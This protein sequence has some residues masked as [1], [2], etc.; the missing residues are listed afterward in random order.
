MRSSSGACARKL[1]VEV[2][3][4]VR[5]LGY[6][7]APPDGAPARLMAGTGMTGMASPRSIETRLLVTGL[8]LSGLFLLITGFVLSSYYRNA[9]E[10][11][12]DESLKVSAVALIADVVTFVEEPGRPPAI[13]AIRASTFS[14]PAGTG[15]SR[16]RPAS[17][18]GRIKRETVF[19]SPSLAADAIPFLDETAARAGSP[20]ERNALIGGHDG[21]QLRLTEQR[22]DLGP[23][24]VFIVSVAGDVSEI[25]DQKRGFDLSILIAFAALGVALALAT[26]AQVRFGLNP[27]RQLARALAAIR[28]GEAERIDGRFP[29]EIAPVAGEIKPAD[30]RQS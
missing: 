3:Q 17:R 16:G 10:R 8:A 6:I 13:S 5:G 26:L 20:R 4:T 23:D 25:E 28:Q 22:V 15:R 9:A 1:G 12:L 24:G 11:F 30:R 14:F 21:R 7:A 27:L 29:R 18:N 2:I 19:A